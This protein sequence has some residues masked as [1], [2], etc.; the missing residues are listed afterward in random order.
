M[1]SAAGRISLIAVAFVACALGVWRLRG[2]LREVGQ[3]LVYSHNGEPV[4]FPAILVRPP[5][6]GKAF[7]CLDPVIVRIPPE[8]AD[9]G[10]EILATG[11]GCGLLR[12]MV[13]HDDRITLPPPIRV[14]VEVAGTHDLPSGKYGLSLQFEAVGVDPETASVLG[15]GPVAADY[16]DQTGPLRDRQIWVDPLTRTASALLPCTGRWRIKWN[17]TDRGPSLALV[18]GTGESE[19]SVDADGQRLTLTIAAQDLESI[20][21]PS[22]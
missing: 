22:R 13:S 2:S 17:H 20:M 5:D 3:C 9:S 16:W 8:V 11:P 6:G 7:V 19:V 4:F 12:G 15:R 1:A 18:Y 14:T 21:E 10:G